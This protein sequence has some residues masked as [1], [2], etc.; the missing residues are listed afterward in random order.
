MRILLTP[1][2]VIS[3]IA[4]M[5]PLAWAFQN[6]GHQ[7]RVATLPQG[8]DTVARAGLTAV[9]VGP[10]T[11][12]GSL[13]EENPGEEVMARVTGLRGDG[14]ER[15]NGMRD[16]A[17]GMVAVCGAAELGM[18][19]VL[20]ETVD[21]ARR[22]RPDL[23][24]QDPLALHGAI[25]ARV[26]GAVHARHLNGLDQVL[27][28]RRNF[29]AHRDGAAG[30]NAGNAGDAGDAGDDVADL[31]GEA[32]RRFGHTFDE[33]VFT[34]HF[35]IDPVPPGLRYPSPVPVVPTRWVGFGSGAV[36][37]DWLAE[38]PTAPRVC[39]SSSASEQEM[40][41]RHLLASPELLAAVRTLDVEVVATFTRDQLPA[42]AE[43][44]DHV[45]LAGFV[46]FEALMPTCSALVFH[47]SICSLSW[48][49][50]HRV[51]Q[52]I[53]VPADGWDEVETA[54]W[55]TRHGSGIALDEREATPEA[56]REALRR[57]LADPA[58]RAGTERARAEWLAMPGPAA[59]V[60]TVEQLTAAYRD[61]LDRPAGRDRVPAG[62]R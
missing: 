32:L 31:L 60:P 38:P 12:F 2:P 26:A 27:R 40:W 23:V 6:A 28:L 46:P 21:F 8:V 19:A 15:D 48:A 55:V 53:V 34:G 16:M 10:E 14:T 36:V 5:V 37:P 30:G 47:G 50:Q 13:E 24:L 22:W 35:A 1:L 42:E 51:P 59:T 18:T 9:P 56:V 43:V 33:E 7:V 61:A 57:V 25:A 4:A 20:D 52:V 49:L 11:D 17:F 62:A 58:Y 54:A 41:R 39:L 3:H 44:G 45:R 29:L